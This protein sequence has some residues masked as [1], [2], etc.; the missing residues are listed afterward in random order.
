MNKVTLSSVVEPGCIGEFEDL[1][2]EFLQAE[3]GEARLAVIAKATTAAEKITDESEKLSAKMYLITMNKFVEKGSEFIDAEIIR[4]KNIRDG[5]LSDKKK[6]Q[7]RDRLN[8]LNSFRIPVK[9][10]L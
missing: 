7:F 1:T 2:K 9:D 8:I 3:D 5:K 10:E 4:V 6:Q